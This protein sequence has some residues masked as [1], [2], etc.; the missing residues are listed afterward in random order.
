MFES[1]LKEARA[2]LAGPMDRVADG[3]VGWRVRLQEELQDLGVTWLD[4]THKPID[5]GCEDLENRQ[6]RAE[7][8]KR[9]QYEEIA[10]HVRELRY[11]DLRMVDVSDFLVVHVD[12]T[13]HMCGTY[14]E[15]FLA[16]DQRKPIVIHIEGGFQKCP[17]W[18]FG[19]VPWQ[20]MFP[21]WPD[22]YQ[23]LRDVAF[24]FDDET[25]GRWVLFDYDRCRSF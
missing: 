6:R 13:V 3:G 7:L 18:L 19:E 17:D 15:L 24:G 21:T 16:N 5:A 23:Y 4:P 25:F 11:V 9:G 2:Y 10:K 8:K 12:V 1:K 20:M 14:R 22:L